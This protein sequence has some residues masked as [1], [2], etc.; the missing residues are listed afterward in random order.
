MAHVKECDS[1][2]K[3]PSVPNRLFDHLVVKW[4]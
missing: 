3:D 1:E 4:S 2:I